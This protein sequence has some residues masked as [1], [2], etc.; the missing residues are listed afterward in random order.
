[1]RL[2]KYSQISARVKT[3]TAIVGVR[4]TTFGVGVQEVGYSQENVSKKAQDSIEDAKDTFLTV[5]HCFEG[6][7]AVSALLDNS[8]QAVEAGRS[9]EVGSLFV[10]TVVPT[11]GYEGERFIADTE[12]LAPKDN[13]KDIKTPGDKG[14]GYLTKKNKFKK[15][16]LKKLVK[17]Q[18]ENNNLKR[19]FALKGDAATPVKQAALKRPDKKVGYFQNMLSRKMGESFSKVNK[20]RENGGIYN[21]RHEWLTWTDRS[22]NISTGFLSTKTARNKKERDFSENKHVERTDN[23]KSKRVT[24]NEKRYDFNNPDISKGLTG[25]AHENNL[26]AGDIDRAREYVFMPKDYPINEYERDNPIIDPNVSGET[27]IFEEISTTGTNDIL[28]MTGGLNEP[29]RNL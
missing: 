17:K 25:T 10:G 13:E 7:V 15:T 6:K 9:L 3:P 16:E 24:G 23:S 19:K 1:L 8:L 12:D 29:K 2:F 4:G 22:K 20:A 21:V 18:K 5:V 28:N 27:S 14:N 26:N 11:K